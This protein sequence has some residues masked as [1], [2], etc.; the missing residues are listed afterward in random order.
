MGIQIPFIKEFEFE[1]E[2]AEQISP[3]IRRVVANNPGPFTYTGTTSF[4]IGHGQVGILDPGPV[5]PTHLDAL[6]AAVEGETVTHILV[7][8]THMDHS[9][10]AAP[11]KERT[12]ALLCGYGPHGTG[13]RD[14]HVSLETGGDRSFVPDLV[15]RDG[16][17]VTGPG[18]TLECLHTPGHTSNHICYALREE[19][20]LFTGDHVMAWSTS[21]VG[22]PDGNMSEY[23]DN[24]ERLLKRDDACYMPTHGPAIPDPKPFVRAYIDHRLEREHQITDCLEKD[25]HYIKEM[26]PLMYE[27]IDPRLIPAAAVSVF[28]QMQRLVKMDKV[29]CA[30]KTQAI[31]SRYALAD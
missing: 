9:P 7:S 18:W 23:M 26:V 1:Y 20:V 30:D 17:L 31:D 2:K 10:G 29:V 19:K 25:I 3:L 12:G 22:P 24:L 21:I 4:I 15:L 28:A 8:H 16:D 11:L 13:G 27:D 14:D 5:D 6:L